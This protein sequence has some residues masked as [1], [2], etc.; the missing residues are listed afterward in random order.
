M[1]KKIIL[2]S[3][4]ISSMALAFAASMDGVSVGM[5]FSTVF[6]VRGFPNALGPALENTIDVNTIL[7]PPPFGV[8][9]MNKGSGGS[10]GGGGTIGGL[11]IPGSTMGMDSGS[12]SQEDPPTPLGSQNYIIFYY[13]HDVRSPGKNFTPNY[14][15]YIFINRYTGMVMSS[16]V[17]SVPGKSPMGLNPPDSGITLGSSMVQLYTILGYNDCSIFQIGEFLVY[18]Y[19][20]RDVTYSVSTVTGKVVG[21]CI[22]KQPMTL[23]SASQASNN[24]RATTTGSTNASGVASGTL[25]AGS[26]GRSTPPPTGSLPGLSGTT[27]YQ[28]QDGEL[29]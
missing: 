17:W 11:S 12:S 16:I 10:S 7:T 28:R 29:Y 8:P 27:P 18:H 21:I 14:N 26:P 6:D 3:L 25:P 19:Y 2:I 24:N 13:R 1:V 5:E 4:L 23:D 9:S 22:G 20:K 15:T